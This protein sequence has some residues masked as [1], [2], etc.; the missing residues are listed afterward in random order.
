MADFSQLQAALDQFETDFT[1]L[2]TLQ[3][4]NSNAQS[5]LASAQTA[6]GNA[7]AAM[8]AGMQQVLTDKQ[9]I[10]SAIDALTGSQ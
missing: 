2:Q 4:A 5:A 3:Q 8:Q 7:Q 6:A 9:A 10:D 1:N